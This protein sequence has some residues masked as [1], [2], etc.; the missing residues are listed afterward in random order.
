MKKTPFHIVIPARYASTRLG[1]KMLKDVAGKQLI[2]RT[3]EQAIQC[4]AQS[5]TI[6][7][8][9]VRIQEVAAAFG[10]PVC[11]TSL[12]HT[13]G[14][15][16][17]AEAASILGF[18][19]DTIVVNVQGD[20]PLL[21]LFAVLKSVQQLAEHPMAAVATLCT[22]ILDKELFFN[23]NVVKVVLDAQGFA[24]YFSRAPIP[25][26]REASEGFSSAYRHVGVYAYRASLLQQFLSWAPSS[27]EQI[28]LLEPLRILSQGEKIHVS[29]MNEVIPA[30]VDTAADLEKVRSHFP[31]EA[32]ASRG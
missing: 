5:V 18:S 28:E 13:C 23:P 21:P 3:Y 10:A 26:G 24:L 19:D 2:Q 31:L 25:W 4:G 6:A 32:L 29:V 20:E 22:P 14:T 1:E 8:D 9:D 27:L 16:R 7:T 30:G 15:E 12:S 11:M 17:L